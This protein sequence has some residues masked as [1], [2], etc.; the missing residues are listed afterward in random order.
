MGVESPFKAML[1]PAVAE[2]NAIP[3]TGLVVIVALAGGAGFV[4]VVPEEVDGGGL[5]L[6][7]PMS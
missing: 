5:L 7:Q 1:P 4:V 3:I 6:A 2:S